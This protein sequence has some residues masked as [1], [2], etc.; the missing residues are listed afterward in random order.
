MKRIAVI[1][2]PGSWSTEKLADA[3][4][5]KTGFR[6]VVDMSRVHMNLETGALWFDGQDL[7]RF[8]A[9]T[10]KKIGPAYSPDMQD[11]LSMLELLNRNGTP[12]FSKPCAILTALNRLSCTVKLRAGDMPMPPTVITESP[13]QAEQAV[14]DFG[15]AVFKPLYTSK[16]RGMEVIEAGAACR[17][18]ISRFQSRGNPV[19]YV[20]KMLTTPGKDLGIVFLGGEY[21]GTYARQSNGAWNTSTSSG[22]KY[23]PYAPSREIIDL[24]W[25]A[26]DLFELDFTCVDIMETE[27]G[28]MIFEVSAFGGFRGLLEACSLDASVHF[29]DHVLR[30]CDHVS[31]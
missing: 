20:Q 28:P 25:R 17:E 12:V 10:V 4:A 9:L 11:R 23:K 19:M 30:R 26:Q 22:G 21:L 18:R 8:D 16:A 1:G 27:D 29:A 13:E 14:A 2:N 15:R 3:F 7:S 31:P 5:A 24:A 6:C